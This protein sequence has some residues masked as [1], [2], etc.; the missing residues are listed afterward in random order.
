MLSRSALPTVTRRARASVFARRSYQSRL[1]YEG[2][3]SNETQEVK[4]FVDKP[5]RYRNFRQYGK[6]RTTVAQVLIG[7]SKAAFEDWLG[8]VGR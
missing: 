3:D 6:W 8:R 7:L 4:A 2:E 5:N 1:I